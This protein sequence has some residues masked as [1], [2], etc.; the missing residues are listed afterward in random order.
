VIRWLFS[1]L[2]LIAAAYIG[3]S[4]MSRAHACDDAC[5]TAGQG[6]GELQS[7]GGGRFNSGIRC[8]CVKPQR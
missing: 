5:A 6:D 2:A 7:Y 1:I 3:Y 8:V 4:V